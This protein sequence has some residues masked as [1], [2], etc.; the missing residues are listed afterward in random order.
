MWDQKQHAP[1]PYTTCA[2]VVTYNPD[3]DLPKR[4]ACIVGQVDSVVII[5][6]HSPPSCLKMIKELSTQFR[7]HLI[8]N[9][10]NLGIGAAQNQGMCYAIDCGYIWA[11]T[12]DQ[13]SICHMT[14]VRNLMTAYYDCPFQEK[15]GIVGSNLQDYNSGRVA[16]RGEEFKGRSWLEVKEVVSSGS[17]ISLPIFKK[18]GSFRGDLFIDH[19][20]NEYCLRLRTGGYKIIIAREIGITHRMGNIQMH[21]LFWR[22]IATY[23]YPPI[24]SYYRTRNSLLLAREYFYK[25]KKWALSRLTRPIKDALRVILLEDNKF[26]KIKYICLGIWHAMLSKY[27]KLYE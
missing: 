20:D 3:T 21:K 27:G 9:N 17:L 24:R 10:K 19:V 15:V 5:D 4:L 14:M 13:D 11:L 2:I 18:M 6:N 23:N 16:V 25:Q 8:A 7:I 26:N 12:L 22:T 1:T